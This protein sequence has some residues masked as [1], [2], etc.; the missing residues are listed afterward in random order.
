[1]NLGDPMALKNA[2]LSSEYFTDCV[3]L[4]VFAS[5]YIF[6][7]SIVLF[8]IIINLD[9]IYIIISA[10]KTGFWGFGVLGFWVLQLHQAGCHLSRVEQ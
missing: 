8:I 5:A 4:G 7:L 3:I 6:L 2:Y 10:N 1:M 9:G